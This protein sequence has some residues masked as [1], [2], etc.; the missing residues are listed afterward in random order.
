MTQQSSATDG[1]LGRAFADALARRDFRGAGE[2]LHPEV[3]FQALTPRRLWEA[4]SDTDVVEV[5]RTWFGDAET[6]QVARVETDAV[7][8]RQ[9]VAYRFRG[10]RPDGPF[11]IEQQAYFTQHDG[12]IDWMRLVCS[13]FRAP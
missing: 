1:R 13:G 12:R 9:H 2:L 10:H 4:L 3:D 5:L 7:A 8:D 11:V 6:E